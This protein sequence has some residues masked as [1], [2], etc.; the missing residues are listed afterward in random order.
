MRK[1]LVEGGSSVFLFAWGEWK[2]DRTRLR[3]F[4]IKEEVMR[5]KNP[6]LLLM[7]VS[8]ILW[9]PA[10]T[11]ASG[12]G[13]GISPDQA[14]SRLKEGN[15]RYAGGNARHPNQGSDRRRETVAVGQKPFATILGC[16]DSRVPV[17]VIFDSGIG[18]LFVIRVAG[19]VADVDE[20][21]SIEYGVDH[22][23][24]PICVVLG[25]TRCGAVTAVTQKAEVH[26]SIPQLVDNIEPAVARARSAQP[27]LGVDAL[28]E[29][30]IKEN[31]WQSIEDL[32][33]TSEVTRKR[34]REGSLKVV[35]A[36]YDL[37]AGKVSWLG[38]HPKEKALVAR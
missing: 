21:G 15:E 16:S 1:F 8:L 18:D 34:V 9:S 4:E 12:G 25:H 13:G 10:L 29:E 17:E 35:A 33:T 37:E 11:L 20:I 7:V 28:V 19:N 2:G 6:G 5:V 36:I 38:S 30:A 27:Q 14:M 23:E 26:G 3:A 32:L 31:A 24:T 22:L